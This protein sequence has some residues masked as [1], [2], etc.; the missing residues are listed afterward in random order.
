MMGSATTQARHAPKGPTRA[1]KGM[2][3]TFSLSLTRHLFGFARLHGWRK[4]SGASALPTFAFAALALPLA[5]GSAAAQGPGPSEPSSST[6]DAAK[7]Q[8]LPVTELA[9]GLRQPWA[10]A[11]LP[12]GDFLV[13]ERAGAMRIVDAHGRVGPALQGV[14]TVAAEG[15]GGLLDLV[16]D[17]DFAANRRVFFCFAE[18]DPGNESRSSTALAS[19]TL[20]ERADRLEDVRVLF[21]QMPRV[22][23]GAHFGC[24]IV[25][26]GDGSLF[27]TL[28]ERSIAPEQAQRTS[29][30]LGTIVRVQADGKPHPDNPFAR[31]GGGKP[32]IW[33]WG[34]RN[35]QGIALTPEGQ[36]W[37]HE[38]GPQGGDEFNWVRPGGN[39][40][41]PAQTFGRGYAASAARA[42]QTAMIAP[43]HYWRAPIQPSSLLYMHSERYGAAWQGSFVAGSLQHGALVRLRVQDQAV[44]E[45]AWFSLPKGQRVRDV[46]QG[47]DGLL[48]VL[49][50]GPNGRLLRVEPPPPPPQQQPAP[51]PQDR[52]Q[53]AAGELDAAQP[54]PQPAPPAPPAL[55]E[56]ASG[57]PNLPG[58]ADAA[59]AAIPPDAQAE[60][61][62]PALP[63]PEPPAAQPVEPAAPLS[64]AADAPDTPVR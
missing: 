5:W 62:A 14:P 13:T 53:P 6:Y 24:R 15:A 2:Q 7:A 29:N 22:R 40:G 12:N 51:A 23:S 46:R 44:Q 34:H 37:A 57:Q 30:H 26:S 52:Y 60:T 11:P 16:L 33:S 28:G 21:H 39:Y 43:V 47:H 50:D 4:A 35:P 61:A 48:Y 1:A 63:S 27:L 55:A 45:E 9:Y 10:F 19:A 36:L 42:R 38:P 25:Q 58:Q 56:P 59:A 8:P 54:Q 31:K 32:E 20:S 64:P 3:K 41:W 18:P 49:T 17:R